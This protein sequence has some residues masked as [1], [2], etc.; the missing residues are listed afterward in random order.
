MWNQHIPCRSTPHEMLMNRKWRHVYMWSWAPD[1]VAGNS[2]W[3]VAGG[4]SS[5]VFGLPRQVFHPVLQ[6]LL[7]R[8]HH[9][10][11]V[12]HCACK[13]R[14]SVKTP[15][16]KCLTSWSRRPTVELKGIFMGFTVFKFAHRHA[17]QGQFTL[18]GEIMSQW[19]HGKRL[20]LSFTMI[21]WL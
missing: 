17:S 21:Q 5:G 8:A 20:A 13:H 12:K 7:V 14:N 15:S 18:Q 4:R 3:F 1:R 19:H 6:V 16:T 11:T 10:K 9:L 2:E